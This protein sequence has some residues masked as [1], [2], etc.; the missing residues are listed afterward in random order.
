MPKTYFG[1]NVPIKKANFGATK[2]KAIYKGTSKVWSGAIQPAKVISLP[3]NPYFTMSQITDASG[4]YHFICLAGPQGNASPNFVTPKPSINIGNSCAYMISSPSG[5]A[6]GSFRIGVLT[7]TLATTYK[8]ITFSSLGITYNMDTEGSPAVL[9]GGYQNTVLV[10]YCKTK[11]TIF[12]GLFMKRYTYNSASMTFDDGVETSIGQVG[13]SFRFPYHA[14]RQD[15]LLDSSVVHQGHQAYSIQGFPNSLRMYST[16]ITR[17][18]NSISLSNSYVTLDGNGTTGTTNNTTATLP[19]TFNGSGT[20]YYDALILPGIASNAS[21]W[22]LFASYVNG[23]NLYMAAASQNGV[24]TNPTMVSR[25]RTDFN[26]NYNGT[27]SVGVL[28]KNSGI[29]QGVYLCQYYYD[30]QSTTADGV[31]KRFKY[32]GYSFQGTSTPTAY[33]GSTL[34]YDQPPTGSNRIGPNVVRWAAPSNYITMDYT[35]NVFFDPSAYTPI[36]RVNSVTYQDITKDIDP[37]LSSA[38]F[39]NLAAI[40]CGI[41][42]AYD[43]ATNQPLKVNGKEVYSFIYSSNPKANDLYR[44]N[45]TGYYDIPWVGNTESNLKQIIQYYVEDFT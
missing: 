38:Q 28:M 13:V 42:Y 37:P 14:F 19:A 6:N 32:K 17:N 35:P 12:G 18:Q 2:L 26:A 8:E 41:P 43:L 15:G 39:L 16:T 23:T 31:S 4:N 1:N 33:D 9:V 7:S 36:Q 40:I 25:N 21:N 34:F 29:S 5:F 44:A 45:T 20:S 11:S 10:F 27:S 22:F 3:I 24:T 30:G